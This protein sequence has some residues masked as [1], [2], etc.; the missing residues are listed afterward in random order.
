MEK[1]ILSDQIAY[2]SPTGNREVAVLAP[3]DWEQRWR[4]GTTSWDLGGVT[5]SLVEYCREKNPRGLDV[6]VP[7]CGR[8][9]DAHFLARQ[10]ARVVALDYAPAAL[11]AARTTHPES[12][13]DWQIA[14]VT[15]LD[16]KHRFDLVWEYTCFCALDP[17]RRQAYLAGVARALRP[18][19]HYQGLVFHSFPKSGGPPWPVDVENFRD[20]L[21]TNLAIVAFEEN[22]QRSLKA[23][24][25]T[26]IWF[27]ARKLPV[28][29][30]S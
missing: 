20:L 17:P 30:P 7:G 13:V 12:R 19:G 26:E 1:L 2:N 18:G 27:S 29:P 3:E 11:E 15:V 10:G 28:V 21:A 9:Y 4:E 6:L 8:G 22:T 16:F 14:D 25:N 23:R 5:P 24:L